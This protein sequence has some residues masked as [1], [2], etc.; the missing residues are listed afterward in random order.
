MAGEEA[1]NGA[2]ILLVRRTINAAAERLFDAWTSGDELRQ[3]WGPPGAK[4]PQAEV[5]LRVG[6]RYRIAN[7][8]PD[9]RVIWIA[10]EFEAIQRPERLVYTWRIEDQPVAERVTVQFR[11]LGQH[12]T[13]IV[14]RH[15][16]IADEAAQ[17][18]HLL[19]W[20][21]CLDGLSRYMTAESLSQ[22]P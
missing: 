16:R 6:G 4:C 8:F 11:R 5:D 14:I 18:E 1:G 20:Q 17:E 15:E 22:A 9:G 12:R 3:W 2:L 10:G 7:Q 19:G 21:G 13:E